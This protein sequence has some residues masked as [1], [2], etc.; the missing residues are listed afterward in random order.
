MRVQN[1][2]AV[3]ACVGGPGGG[4]WGVGGI[5]IS[6]L[7]FL[8]WF[9]FCLAVSGDDG[10]GGLGGGL[11]GGE[12]G[13]FHCAWRGSRYVL[14]CWVVFLGGCA[15]AGGVLISARCFLGSFVFRLTA[16]GVA[17]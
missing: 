6:A 8:G 4:S 2:A 15:R 1:S 13:W 7:C 11:G 3:V 5:F 12:C 17:V 9:E 16:S 10:G 14:V